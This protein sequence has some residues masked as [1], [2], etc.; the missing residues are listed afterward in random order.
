MSTVITEI[1]AQ[2]D[3]Y[4]DSSSPTTNFGTLDFGLW[5]TGFGSPPAILRPILDFDTSTAAK[6]LAGHTIV[7]VTL[8]LQV[9]SPATKPALYWWEQMLRTDWSETQATW[10]MR[11]A[12]MSWAEAGCSGLG[13]DYIEEGRSEG[14][15]P[16]DGSEPHLHTTDEMKALFL[17]TLPGGRLLLRGRLQDES[18][19]LSVAIFHSRDAVDPNNRPRLIIVSEPPPPPPPPPSLTVAEKIL[20]LK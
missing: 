19:S 8:S 17:K 9:I 3:S 18:E 12:L 13:L 10:Q 5:G 1:V 4:L 2:A 6:D 20:I 15:L 14:R 16:T 11:N 7:S